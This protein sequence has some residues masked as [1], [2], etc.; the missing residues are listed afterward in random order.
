MTSLVSYGGH[1]ADCEVLAP[2]TIDELA[3][4]LADVRAT[5]RH[6]TF[7]G[8]AHSFDRQS[9]NTNPNLI[10][11]LDRL[12]GLWFSADGAVVAAAGGER[13][14][15]LVSAARLRGR[16]P[17]VMVTTEDASVAGTVSGNCVSRFSPIWGQ[18]GDHVCAIEVM[19]IDGHRLLCP[20]PPVSMTPAPSALTLPPPL[21]APPGLAAGPADLFYG[22]TGGLGYL[23]A[24]T[25]VDIALPANDRDQVETRVVAA[26][27]IDEVLRA[28]LPPPSIGAVVLPPSPD[29]PTPYAML[30]PN[31]KRGL[32]FESRYVRGE[33]LRPF[34]GVHQPRSVLRI[35]SEFALYS[36]TLARIGY[37]FTYKFHRA[38][39]VDPLLDFT[40]FMEGNARA[41]RLGRRLG[42]AM[43]IMQQSFVIPAEAHGLDAAREFIEVA[44]RTFRAARIWPA[45]NDVLYCPSDEG[46]MSATHRLPGFVV[47]FAFEPRTDAR[48]HRIERAL[49]TL[50][51]E[52][53]RLGGRV[54]L[55]KSVH[56]DKDDL[57]EMYAATLPRFRALRDQLDPMHLLRNPFLEDLFPS[58]L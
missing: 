39:Y 15:A 13:W 51:H 49:T 56:A 54:H 7:R 27:S 36:Q 43:R 34:R 31:L 16:L 40:F 32:A 38:R 21:A 26:G 41:R 44:R 12:R 18:D 25:R 45:M 8:G 58:L 19:T 53:G 30:L 6:L 37:W 10:L 48:R 23:A 35:V 20:R 50:S 5:G 47:T 28:C 46:L 42:F 9:L 17:A 52:C 33:R 57:A 22:L 55:T 3:L 14:G 4:V 11:S 2:S 24:I 1:R 29:T